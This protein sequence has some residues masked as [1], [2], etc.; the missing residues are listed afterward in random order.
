[1]TYASKSFKNYGIIDRA[2]KG[3]DVTASLLWSSSVSGMS[4]AAA[5]DYTVCIVLWDEYRIL[6]GREND[7]HTPIIS[8]FSACERQRL[9]PAIVCWRPLASRIAPIDDTLPLAR[10]YWCA[11]SDIF[12]ALFGA[13]IARY[14]TLNRRPAISEMQAA[15]SDVT[16]WKP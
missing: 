8:Q 16:K 3:V 4:A 15:P 5:A 2:M 13:T 14:N 10:D 11:G 1:M 12:W 9:S 7:L 6:C